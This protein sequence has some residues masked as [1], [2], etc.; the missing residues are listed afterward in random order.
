MLFLEIIYGLVIVPKKK[1]NQ[2]FW[3]SV[4]FGDL[5]LKF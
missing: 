2:Y 5:D 4:A 1:K 3:F